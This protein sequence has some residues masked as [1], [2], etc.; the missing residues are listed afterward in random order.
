MGTK[1]TPGKAFR[2]GFVL[3]AT[4]LASLPASAQVTSFETEGNLKPTHDLACIAMDEIRNVYT[5]ADLMAAHV[6]CRD[7]GQFENAFV[8]LLV[9]G[10]YARFDTLRVSDQTAH[11]AFLVLEANSQ[12]D[13]KAGAGVKAAADP[14]LSP[15]SEKMRAFCTAIKRLGPPDYYP[16]YMVRHGMGAFFGAGGGL[17]VNF[18]AKAGWKTSLDSWLHCDVSDL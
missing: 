4:L 7:A 9:A 13:E 15:G 2:A 5:P 16:A 3:L 12:P 14:Y 6:K 8:L 1:M 18:D 10:T 11:D 17:V